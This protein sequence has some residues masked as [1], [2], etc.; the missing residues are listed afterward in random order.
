MTTP[1]SWEAFVQGVCSKRKLPKFSKL[2]EDC[3]Q[4]EARIAARD[5]KLGSSEDQAL[6][7]H[8]KKGRGRRNQP[9]RRPQSD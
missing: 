8:A 6:T 3:I 2:W 1:R 4:E 9:P 5:E 7:A